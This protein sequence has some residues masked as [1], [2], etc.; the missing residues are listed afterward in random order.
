M[1]ARVLIVEREPESG[2]VRTDRRCLGAEFEIEVLQYPGRITP[3]FVGR[4]FRSVRRADVVYAFFASEHALVPALLARVL[5][6]PFL[7]IPAGYD[8]ANVPEHHYGL[9]ARGHGWLPKL[10]G[11]CAS[12]ALPISKQA[13]WEFL[14]LVPSAAPRTRL[15]YLGVDPSEW[16]DPEVERDA[17]LLVTVGYVDDEAWSRKGVDR[18][19]EM[20]RV[21]PANRYVL[22]GRLTPEIASRVAGLRLDNLETPGA[23]SHDELRRLY[24]SAAAY[25]QLSWHETFGM[26]MAEAMLCGC[27]PVITG[28]PALKEV[29]GRWAIEA[30]PEE[31]DID[32]GRRALE[33]ARGVSVVD[34]RSDVSARFTVE[35][36]QRALAAAVR[37]LVVTTGRS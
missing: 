16:D 4:C 15:E 6:R 37:E 27:V 18:F 35:L 33:L 11:R 10:V 12:V 14:S 36:R 26:A 25:V 24:W 9:A 34:I 31:S 32:L 1:T 23:L 5:G 7:L 19:V 21:D 30:R 20:A 28:S 17:N 3:K 8:Y 2:F 22:A 13:Q 29:A